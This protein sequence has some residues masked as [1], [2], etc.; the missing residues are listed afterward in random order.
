MYHDDFE[1]VFHWKKFLSYSLMSEQTKVLYGSEVFMDIVSTKNISS[2]LSYRNR[3]VAWG[4]GS[5]NAHFI[6]ILSQCRRV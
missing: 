1:S 4:N 6:N 2:V 3:A 5:P